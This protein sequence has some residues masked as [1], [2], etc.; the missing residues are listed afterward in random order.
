MHCDGWTCKHYEIYH[1]HGNKPLDLIMMGCLEMLI[2]TERA[3]LKR[4]V[5]FDGQRSYSEYREKNIILFIILCFCIVNVCNHPFCNIPATKSFQPWW[6]WEQNLL[7][8]SFWLASLSNI[9]TE[10]N[11]IS[12]FIYT[13]S[14]E[15]LHMPLIWNPLYKTL[16]LI[17]EASLP[18][19]VYLILLLFLSVWFSHNILTL[20]NV[21]P[22]GFL[23][24]F[25]PLSLGYLN[26]CYFASDPNL[27]LFPNL[28]LKHRV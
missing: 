23:L 26:N 9:Y 19:F 5:P 28:F 10:P 4:V 7:F 15:K 2:E 11:C 25:V 6:D 3:A 16:L 20:K 13:A 17:N 21:D 12:T 1:H 14:S 27:K 8:F 18:I 22:W 24:A